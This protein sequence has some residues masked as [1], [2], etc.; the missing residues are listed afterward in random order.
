MKVFKEKLTDQDYFGHVVNM[1]FDNKGDT[2]KTLVGGI[3]SCFLKILLGIYIFML[4]RKWY[5]KLN[6]TQFTEIG[7]VDLEEADDVPYDPSFLNMMLF[8]SV[9]KQR[10]GPLFLDDQS[11]YEYIDIYF[12]Q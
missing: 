4:F 2:H 5:L 3:I 12:G 11:I 7:L 6:N 1:N 9:K 10:T 8:Y